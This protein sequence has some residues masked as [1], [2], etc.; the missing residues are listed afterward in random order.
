MGA[1]LRVRGSRGLVV[2]LASGTAISLSAIS[3]GITPSIADPG[4]GPTTTPVAPPKPGRQA[5]PSGRVPQVVSAPPSQPPLATVVPSAPAVTDPLP[6]IAAPASP[7]SP[8]PSAVPV[9]TAPPTVTTPVATAVPTTE[10]LHTA[11]P[12]T[13]PVPVTTTI[14]SSPSLAPR[15]EPREVTTTAAPAPSTVDASSISPP[16]TQP[17]NPAA[18]ADGTPVPTHETPGPA[19]GTSASASVPSASSPVSQAG[20]VVDVHQAVTV[21]AP[22]Q[23]VELAKA[24][25]PVQQRPEPAATTDIDDIRKAV[26]LPNAT[27]DGRDDKSRD[28][29]DPNAFRGDRD[30][31]DR[32]Q[33]VRQWDRDWVRYD[34]YH[35][36]ILCNPYHD[37]L[38]VVYIYEYQPRIVLIPPLASIVLDALGYGAYNFTAL[39]LDPLGVAENVAVG[40]FYGGGY[41]P[42]PDVAPPP[43]PP[44]LPTY[45]DVPVVVNYPQ[46]SY[47][48]FTVRQVV[49]VGDD[50]QYGEHKVLL[51]GVTPVWGAWTQTPGGQR[52]FEVHKTQQLPGIDDPQAGPL[53]GD[54]QL[55]LASNPSSGFSAGDLF[56]I[57][58]DAIVGTLALC[59]AAAFVI[60]R[61]RS[62]A[63]H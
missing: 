16:T 3:G 18:S 56:I 49:D 52:Q 23:D 34:D 48:P 46:A 14:P 28:R 51:D 33:R 63:L 26:R 7:P 6:Q 5:P 50:A 40:S 17:T 43:P 13:R 38:R 15:V 45:D 41:Y 20:Q 32:D 62:R 11:P 37:T 39:A 4:A 35:R 27:V 42:G 61:R 58:A 54:Y 36:P 53:P 59:A 55:R 30:D 2:V 44:P 29:H 22:Q 8:P 10:P 19:T 12:T 24:S 9:V 57:A 60:S 21:Q 25:V 31:R 47:E 1:A